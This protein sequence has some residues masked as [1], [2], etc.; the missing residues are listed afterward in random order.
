LAQ[1]D[2]AL[3]EPATDSAR[4][5]RRDPPD[6]Q[7]PLAVVTVPLPAGGGTVLAAEALDTVDEAR[8]GPGVDRRGRSRAG[9]GGGRD[10]DARTPLRE[11]IR[12][13]ARA[14]RQLPAI[15]QGDIDVG[16]GITLRRVRR[17]PV[18]ERRSTVSDKQARGFD[19]AC[20]ANARRPVAPGQADARRRPCA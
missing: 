17:A 14:A 5:L 2:R 4:G 19:D 12:R 10:D 16:L 1:K 18:A 11:G 9:R 3:P 20:G 13:L 7:A 6:R 15:W 8:V